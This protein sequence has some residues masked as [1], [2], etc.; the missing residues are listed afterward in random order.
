MKKAAL[1]LLS[2]V[3]A[4]IGIAIVTSYIDHTVH[5]KELD[6]EYAQY[7]YH[8]GRKADDYFFESSGWNV[9]EGWQFVLTEEEENR[10][11][12]ID[13]WIDLEADVMEEFWSNVIPKTE[14]AS[15]EWV[16]TEGHCYFKAFQ[17][18]GGKAVTDDRKIASSCLYTVIWDQYT[19]KYICLWYNNT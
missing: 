6:S 13:G 18:P 7:C 12:N 19:H 2:M 14:Q 9:R 10:L 11:K 1:V 17:H 5:Y 3:I 4:L 15:D 8:P 16:L